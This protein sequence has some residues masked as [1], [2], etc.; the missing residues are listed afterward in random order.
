VTCG[1]VTE[2]A[3]VRVS[4]LHIKMLALT[5]TDA[6][7]VIDAPTLKNAPSSVSS[8]QTLLSKPVASSW[9]SDSNSLFIASA[10]SIHQYDLSSNSLHQIYSA[11]RADSILHL[12][13]KDNGNAHIFSVSN[14]VHVLEGSSGRITQTFESHKSPITSLALSNDC[15]LLAT[16]SAGAA[17][18][19]H[20]AN[21]SHTVLRGL[22][23][24]NTKIN[25]CL[26]HTHS[27]TR[28]LLSAGRQLLVY[29]TT[30]PS[31]PMKTIAMA[32][33]IPGAIDF[34]ACSPFS[35]TLAA[36]AT[37]GG[38]VCLVDL[39]KEKAYVFLGIK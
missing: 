4:T 5:T 38:N 25:T 31:G 29:D 7:T 37:T 9:P 13:S 32:D 18:V 14:T 2:R 28:L 34:I 19:H 33:S 22:P 1:H 10:S 21:G 8:C 15:T 3:Q 27:R 11:K 12:V 39:E 16:T 6:L 24:A 26:F 20:L 35:K 30:R 23:P 36:F 17:H